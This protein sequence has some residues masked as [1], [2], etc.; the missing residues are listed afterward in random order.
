MIIKNRIA[1]KKYLHVLLCCLVAE[2]AYGMIP[3][4]ND[5]QPKYAIMPFVIGTTCIV[6]AAGLYYFYKLTKKDATIANPDNRGNNQSPEQAIPDDGTNRYAFKIKYCDKENIERTTKYTLGLLPI[7]QNAFEKLESSPV[8]KTIEVSAV[9]NDPELTFQL[10]KRLFAEAGGNYPTKSTLKDSEEYYF[11]IM[12]MNIFQASEEVKKK[13]ASKYCLPKIE[14]LLSPTWLSDERNWLT[15]STKRVTIEMVKYLPTETKLNLENKLYGLRF[16]TKEFQILCSTVNAL[17]KQITSFIHIIQENIRNSWH[18]DCNDDQSKYPNNARLSFDSATLRTHQLP[19]LSCYDSFKGWYNSFEYRLYEQL[20]KEQTNSISCL[21]FTNI[22]QKYPLNFSGK[23]SNEQSKEN[24]FTCAQCNKEYT[25]PSHKISTDTQNTIACKAC[26][27]Y[28]LNGRIVDLYD[29]HNLDR[30]SLCRLIHKAYNYEGCFN[31]IKE[32]DSEA[33][34]DIPHGNRLHLPLLQL[35]LKYY[36]IR[37]YEGDGAHGCRAYLHLGL[38]PVLLDDVDIKILPTFRTGDRNMYDSIECIIHHENE[39]NELLTTTNRVLPTIPKV[40][41]ITYIKQ[42]IYHLYGC[43]PWGTKI[44]LDVTALQTKLAPY[45]HKKGN[46]PARDS[47][48]AKQMKNDDPAITEYIKQLKQLSKLY[49]F[50][51]EK[52]KLSWEW[53]WQDYGA[54]PDRYIY[55]HDYATIT[56]TLP[57]K[58]EPI[59]K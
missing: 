37:Y 30:V 2:T 29:C 46:W 53:W 15:K 34:E 47:K 50:D 26:V 24:I 19:I 58:H 11:F 59:K 25:L 32:E 44:T 45:F 13:I 48:I 31:S 20:R 33:Y 27:K 28:E 41:T 23:T 42:D 36:G 40:V 55:S 4:Y 14:E 38:Y 6:G 51:Y 12:Q 1:Q 54:N 10:L 3:Q 17:T 35:L 22:K 56:I 8:N 52:L 18:Y 39:I 57:I 7:M 43:I 5:T 49:N 16:K 21:E 9:K